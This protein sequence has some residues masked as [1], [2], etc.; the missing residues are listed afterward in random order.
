MVQKLTSR[1]RTEI[2]GGIGSDHA[3]ARYMTDVYQ[4]VTNLMDGDVKLIPH[5]D[6]NGDSIATRFGNNVTVVT[7]RYVRDGVLGKKVMTN[8]IEIREGDVFIDGRK[9]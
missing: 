8:T 6:G 7:K 1:K 9:I 4:E 2:S 3:D 5:T